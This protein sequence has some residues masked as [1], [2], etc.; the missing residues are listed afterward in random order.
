MAT[1]RKPSSAKRSLSLR[2]S[3]FIRLISPFRGASRAVREGAESN[4]PS[5]FPVRGSVLQAALSDSQLDAWARP[6]E[7][8]VQ[9]VSQQ[10]LRFR[11]PLGQ[12][13]LRASQ[14]ELGPRRG[15]GEGAL[16]TPGTGTLQRRAHASWANAEVE[17]E[18]E[19]TKGAALLGR[20]AVSYQNL[21]PTGGLWQG[22]GSPE[23]SQRSRAGFAEDN[24]STTNVAWLVGSSRREQEEEHHI[25]I[26]DEG[27]LQPPSH[28]AVAPLAS[29][30]LGVQA[31]QRKVSPSQTPSPPSSAPPS[32]QQG[33]SLARSKTVSDMP[34]WAHGDRRQERGVSSSSERLYVKA[35]TSQATVSTLGSLRSRIVRHKT[36]LGSSS[37]LYK[38]SQSL[39][40]LTTI[41]SGDS[42]AS[43]LSRDPITR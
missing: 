11:G 1:R 20:T 21:S 42:R 26:R 19:R 36:L 9:W 16:R 3:S 13:D 18:W 8:E 15:P 32:R 28:L 43:T 29:P 33:Y 24:K 27:E 38:F 12:G 7:K 4:P 10:E 25:D 30:R 35:A 37:R 5:P 17:A 39:S 2:S 31:L 22:E 6:Q 23:A 14:G 34:F 40:S 41:T